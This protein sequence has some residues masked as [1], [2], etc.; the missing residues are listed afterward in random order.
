MVLMKMRLKE[1]QGLTAGEA[2]KMLRIS[3]HRVERLFDRGTL[4]GWKNP[5]TG[6]RVVDPKS[7]KTFVAFNREWPPLF[8][9]P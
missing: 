7:V 3:I 5:V 4:T 6:W 8:V 9:R 1:K 2:S